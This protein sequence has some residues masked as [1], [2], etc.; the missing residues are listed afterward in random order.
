MAQNN[1]PSLQNITFSPIAF[2]P[3]AY[4]PIESRANILMQQSIDKK[5]L[6]R[7]NA[8]TGLNAI[9]TE[10]EKLR[11]TMSPDNDTQQWLTNYGDKVINQ[12]QSEIDAGNYNSAVE[13]AGRL[14]SNFI[15]AQIQGR[16]KAYQEWKTIDDAY[17]KGVQ[18]GL[19]NSRDYNY[20]RL[21]NDVNYTPAL[22]ASG[23]ERTDIMGTFTR[24]KELLQPVDYEDIIT[25]AASGPAYQSKTTGGKTNAD[26]TG[27]GSSSYA[28]LTKTQIRDY[29][30]ELIHDDK[31]KAAIKQDYNYSIK[32]LNELENSNTLTDEQSKRKQELEKLL[33]ANNSY[34]SWDTYAINVMDDRLDAKAYNR[35]STA[36]VDEYTK[37]SNPKYNT[38]EYNNNTYNVISENVDAGTLI[39]QQEGSSTTITINKNKVTNKDWN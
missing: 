7:N 27:Y 11:T 37:Q 20:W 21:E 12:I 22:N 31:Y 16:Q 24:P 23:E 34:V 14:G 19:Y 8:N 3:I 32:E 38:V 13:L 30:K 6:A 17:Y 36:S 39:L 5:Q 18:S 35:Q 28:R 1:I 10:V 9:R 25:K 26:G 2:Q 4:K 29:A 33:K 15:G